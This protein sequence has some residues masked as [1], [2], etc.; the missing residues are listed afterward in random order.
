[1]AELAGNVNVVYIL[2]GTT[3]MTNS[4]GAKVLGVNNSQ[5][6]QLCSLLDISQFGDT[7]VKRK[8]GLKDGSVSLSG[9]YYPGDTNGQDSIT[10]GADLYIGVYPQGT[11]VAGKQMPVIVEN[12]NI[13]SAV[14]GLQTFTA[15]LQGNGAAVAL[16]LRP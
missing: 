2:A 15:S 12:F 6:N 4:T 9:N 8:A 1:M 7:N 3:A 14:N 13:S 16:P 5:F 11:G 10:A